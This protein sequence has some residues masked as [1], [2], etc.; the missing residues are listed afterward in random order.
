[1]EYLVWVWVTIIL[2]SAVAEFF[3]RRLIFVWLIPASVTSGIMALC[4]VFFIWQILACVII[5]MVGIFL[6][7]LLWRDKLI[8]SERYFT[9][10]NIV[11]E[12]CVV[13]ERIDSFAGCGLVKVGAQEWSARGISVD[14]VYEKGEILTVMAIEGVKLICK[15]E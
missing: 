7:Y 2:A 15:K 14:D 6:T 3:T 4:N 11:G 13:I 9:I 12:R 5:Y 10:E 1:M 8:G